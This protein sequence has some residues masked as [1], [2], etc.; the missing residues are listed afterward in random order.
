MG[1]DKIYQR[2]RQRQTMNKEKKTMTGQP[3]TK[4]EVEPKID[5]KKK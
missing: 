1:R 4:V 3:E 2:S 5:E